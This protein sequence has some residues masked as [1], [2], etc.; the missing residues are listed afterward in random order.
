MALF[1][2]LKN[3]I[4]I[5]NHLIRRM[6]AVLTMGIMGACLAII[7][8]KADELQTFDEWLKEFRLQANT[9][10]IRD[11]VMDRAFL[12]IRPNPRVY[13]LLDNQP[14]FTKGIWDYL[15]S[16]LSQ[17]RVNNGRKKYSEHRL[18]LNKVGAQYG[19]DSDVITAIWGLETAY[20]A[21]MGNFDTIQ[22]L[23]SLAYKGRRTGFA[24]SQ[25]IGALEIIQSGYADRKAMRGSWAGAM[26]H[27]QFI[28]TTYLAHA[29]DY[30]GDGKRDIWSNLGDVFASTANY[31]AVSDYR[32]TG[33]AAIEVI[34]PEGFDYALTAGTKK[35]LV[36][37]SALGLVAADNAALY[38]RYDPNLPG[39]IIVPAGANGPA[40][41][42]FPNFEAILKYNRS[43][44]YALAVTLLSQKI[45][46]R[47]GDILQPWPRDDRP[48][49]FAEA[50]QLQQLLK[51]R[52]F[53]PGPVDGIIGA[54][55]RAALRQ[56]Q[57]SRGL[58]AD[59]YASQ[60]TLALLLS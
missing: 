11:D 22:V 51:D 25:L 7:P 34:L 14:E 18:L 28:P 44:S 56:W 37:W 52:G 13:E 59:G 23:T 42:T 16:A 48:L 38:E 57:T 36:E 35:A 46:E 55:T 30:D 58:A 17:T 27:T 24:R 33:P 5:S 54:G 29:I 32:N 15:D 26:G 2:V 50:K 53:N 41:M 12:N 9:R 6:M 47:G 20:G 8:V 45:A 40:F 4:D 43:T 10:G 60:Q 49:S 39:K 3:S 19:V 21:V 31:L 1:N